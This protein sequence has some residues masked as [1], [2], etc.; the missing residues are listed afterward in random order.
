MPQHRLNFKKSVIN[1]HQYGNGDKVLFC[2]HGYG[3]TGSSFEFIEKYLGSI[4]TIYAI[5][6]PFHGST[7]C[8]ARDPFTAEDLFSILYSIRDQAHTRF[9]ILASSMGGRASM[10]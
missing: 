8:H 1:Y 3:E 10:H 7:D 9:S 5:D 6:F 2:L 4:Y